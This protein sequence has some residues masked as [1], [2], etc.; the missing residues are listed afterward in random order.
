MSEELTTD[1]CDCGYAHE[2]HL[3]GCAGIEWDEKRFQRFGPSESPPEPPAPAVD[4]STPRTTK[5]R[6]AQKL[7][8]QRAREAAMRGSHLDADD[9]PLP[10]GWDTAE[11]LERELAAQTAELER[12][13]KLAESNGILAHDE[14]IKSA[15]A[16]GA[17]EIAEI[18]MCAVGVPHDGERAI[19]QEAV[20]TVRA[21]L[22]PSTPAPERD[23]REGE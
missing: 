14:A 18:A 11:F 15:A 16:R 3:S 8:E 17:L 19:L 2:G 1:P 23:G 13:K 22:R 4:T 9:P 21:V 10:D 5:A 7:R 20:D 6:I 12:Y